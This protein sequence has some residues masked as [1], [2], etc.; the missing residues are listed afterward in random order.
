MKR[1]FLTVAALTLVSALVS[2]RA[3]KE[4]D[5][6]KLLVGFS[7]G[8]STT[9]PML[10][11]E[12]GYFEAL[13]V[14]PQFI[15][16]QNSADGLAALDAGKIDVGATFGTSAPLTQAAQG[17]SIVIIA[18]A[19]SGGHP[20]IC[21]PENADQYQ[22]ITGFKGKVVGTPR[23]Y[24]SDIVW[25][26]ALYAAGIVPGQDVEIIEFKRPVDVLE[27]VKSG[28]VDVGIGASALGPQALEAGLAIP[29]YSNDFKANHPCCRI[30]TSQRVLQAKRPELVAFIKALL[31]AE[32]K[33]GAD[34]LAGVAANIN[35]LDLSED[36]ARHFALEPHNNFAVDPNTHA[37]VDMFEDMKR[38]EYLDPALTLDPYSLIDT[39]LY[40]EALKELETEQPGPYWEELRRRFTDWNA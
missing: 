37:V 17:A 2:A 34:P 27:A 9:L 21:K 32:Q 38:I 6:G 22:D 24:T 12:E 29:L 1:V 16:F 7:H 26:G 33:I 4:R 31:L 11:A 13:G 10:A 19:I 39:S 36:V 40:E 25:R 30:V 3:G 18:G 35:Q 28:K 20:V 14:N 5:T 8:A 15:L 23:L